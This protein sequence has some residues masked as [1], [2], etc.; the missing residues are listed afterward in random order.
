MWQDPYTLIIALDRSGAAKGQLY[1]D[2]GTGYGY[3][4]GEYVWR[5]FELKNGILKSGRHEKSSEVKGNEWEK[6]ISHVGIE[7]IVVLG[8]KKPGVV[9]RQDGSEVEWTWE[10]GGKCG[11]KKGEGRASRLILK[12]P[13]VGIT[14]DWGIEIR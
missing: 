13:G 2:D 11:D 5:S 9:R 1:S 7:Q 14:G 3:T 6:K 8:M 12:K 10:D 4:S